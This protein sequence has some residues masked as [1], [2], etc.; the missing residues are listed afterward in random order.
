[1]KTPV[2]NSKNFL[3]PA[4]V[5]LLVS[6]GY[7]F[8]YLQNSIPSTSI[9]IEPD[10]DWTSPT[11]QP[12]FLNQNETEKSQPMLIYSGFIGCSQTCPIALQ[13]MNQISTGK[14]RPPIRFI[15]LNTDPLIGK[16]QLEEYKELYPGIEF[17]TSTHKDPVQQV[18]RLKFT[19]QY[20]LN[21]TQPASVQLQRIH[22]SNHYLL[23][24]PKENRARILTQITEKILWETLGFS[25]KLSGSP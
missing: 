17:Y 12:L 6:L 7:F 22:H 8:P 25:K 9:E 10:P 16:A 18:R 4:L 3:G 5:C 21:E 11:G 13:T 2:L 20:K 19:A 23:V 24:S 14:S 15:F 1:M